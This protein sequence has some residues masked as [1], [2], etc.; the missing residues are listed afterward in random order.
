MRFGFEPKRLK[1]WDFFCFYEGIFSKEDCQNIINLGTE[2][3]DAKVGDGN[4]GIVDKKIRESSVQFLNVNEETLPLFKNLKKIAENANDER[5]NFQLSGFYEG[6]QLTRYDGNQRGK[7]DAHMDVGPGDMSQR[8]LSI[9]VLLSDPD[10]YEGGDLEFIG[11]GD[12]QKIRT[13]G[14]AIVF[15]S[16]MV[17]KVNE[18]TKGVRY[19]L[20]GWISGDPYK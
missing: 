9:V 5:Y 16:Y 20:V 19:S 1:N 13:Q 6:L 8:K 17:H 14:T 7:Y 18:V 3:T 12:H 10:E 15:P 11:V 2:L 4:D